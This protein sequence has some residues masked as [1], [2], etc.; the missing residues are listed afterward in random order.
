MATYSINTGTS[1]ETTT[2]NIIGATAIDL[3]QVLDIL[4]DN[5]D[6]QINPKDIRDA[7]LTSFSNSAFKQT[8]ASQST[9][10]YIGV[11]NVNP[12]YANKDVKSKVYFGKR[13]FSGTYSYS[14]THDLMT[15]DLLNSDVDVFLYNTKKDTV[16]N[17]RTRIAILSGTNSSLYTNSP[18]LQSQV[19][20]V[21][22]YSS[23]S[24]DIINPTFTGGTS[25]VI[26]FN[27]DYGTVSFNQIVFPRPQESYGFVPGLT[28]ASDGRVL[29]WNN[30]VLG[31][32]DILLPDTSYIGATGAP[33]NIYGSTINVN[34]YPFEFTDTRQCTFAMGDIELGETFNSVSIVEMLRRMVY[35]YLPPICSLSILPPYS[36]GY[37]EV[38]S[39]PIIKL[40]YTITKRSLPTQTSVFSYMIPSTY[41]AITNDGQV[42]ISGSVSGVVVTPITSATT[43]FTLTVND[44]TQSNSASAT[45]AGIYPYFYGF[46]SLTTMTTAGLASLTKLVEPKSNKNVDVVG[47]GNFYFIYDSNYPVL[48]AIYNEFGNTI[49]SASFSSP[50]ILTLSSP[51]GLWASKQF[52]VYQYNGVPQ[53]GPPSVNYQFKY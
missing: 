34:G 51:T 32:D 20:T 50:T 35:D 29:K 30:G 44:G 24:L 12:D 39:T 13:A 3:S 27:S 46:S 6:K 48:S 4:P 37:V 2:Y 43:S 47:T 41:P 33:T 14:Y 5:T 53:I 40:G 17:N 31:W 52:R 9:T 21:G 1:I 8:L 49:S 26:N 45:I 16:S 10:S 42:T 19:V 38:G 28:A 11:D 36:S 23:L 22:T 7:I 15:S 25:S 18:Y